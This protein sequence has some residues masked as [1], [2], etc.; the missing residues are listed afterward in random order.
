M[1]VTIAHDLSCSPNGGN[2]RA[3]RHDKVRFE[4]PTDDCV[5]CFDPPLTQNPYPI[6]KNKPIHIL[7]SDF[8]PNTTTVKYQPYASGTTTCPARVQTDLAH[9]IT[10]DN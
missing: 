7:M 10:V 8:P 9:T 2:G 3:K 5:I 6:P 1:K 4:N